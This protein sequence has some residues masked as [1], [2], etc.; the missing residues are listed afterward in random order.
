MK[1]GTRELLF[2]L[3]MLGLMFFAWYFVF[4]KAD[5]RI[6]QRMADTRMKTET[7]EK[8]R[9]ATST[10]KDMEKEIDA[11]QTQLNAFEAKLPHASESNEIVRQVDQQVR[12]SGTLA[13]TAVGVQTA[14]KAA[15][16]YELPIKVGLDGDF[17]SF[18]RF[19][20]SVEAMPR[21]TRVNH[22]H[23]SKMNDKDGKMAIDM[24]LSI[25]FAPDAVAK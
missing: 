15:G 5:E 4:R 11:L 9:I 1:F 7:L 19:L 8:V 16:Y 10:A 24:T 12:Q 2:L 14:E 23:I 3:V 21:I 17:R 25:F 6:S 20:L 13:M 18:Y 22:L